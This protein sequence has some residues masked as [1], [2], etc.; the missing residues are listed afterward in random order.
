MYVISVALVI[1]SSLKLAGFLNIEITERHCNLCYANE[2]GDEFHY[3]FKCTFFKNVRPYHVTIVST[4]CQIYAL[5]IY[6]YT[7]ITL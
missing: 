1:H 5:R 7:I 4:S 6:I 2:L 3:S